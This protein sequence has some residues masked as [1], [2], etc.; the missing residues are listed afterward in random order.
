MAEGKVLVTGGARFI[1]LMG[2]MELPN[3]GAG[4]LQGP[5]SAEEEAQIGGSHPNLGYL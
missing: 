2:Q 3:A 5:Y 4:A 1:G